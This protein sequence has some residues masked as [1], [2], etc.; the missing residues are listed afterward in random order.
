[1]NSSILLEICIFDIIILNVV[2]VKITRS[3]EIV[4]IS[5]MLV[6]TYSEGLRS[7]ENTKTTIKV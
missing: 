1:M 6:C 3:E 4:R 7:N 5:V 2:F